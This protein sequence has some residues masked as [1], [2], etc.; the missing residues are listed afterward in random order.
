MPRNVLAIIGVS[1]FIALVLVG[2]F[3]L[4]SREDGRG[5]PRS[6]P[7]DERVLGDKGNDS[8][9]PPVP[10]PTAQP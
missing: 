1:A 10:S 4:I 5:G 6:Q 8:A 2:G 9:P 3:F 7:T